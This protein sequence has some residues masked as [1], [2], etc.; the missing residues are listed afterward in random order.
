MVFLLQPF[1]LSVVIYNYLLSSFFTKLG[2]FGG[3]SADNVF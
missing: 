1:N 3:D 2:Q